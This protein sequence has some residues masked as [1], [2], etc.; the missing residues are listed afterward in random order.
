MAIVA[1]PGFVPHVT[2]REW[3]D[4]LLTQEAVVAAANLTIKRATY[5]CDAVE[6]W[7]PDPDGHFR[8]VDRIALVGT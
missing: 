1:R 3:P 4:G 2:I 5:T 6:L 8:P 7:Q